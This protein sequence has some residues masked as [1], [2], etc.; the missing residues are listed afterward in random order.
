MLKGKHEDGERLPKTTSTVD[1][2]Q[3]PRQDDAE[4][5]TPRWKPLSMCPMLPESKGSVEMIAV[6]GGC[7]HVGDGSKGN[8]DM[9][10][11]IGAVANLPY[12]VL[13]IWGS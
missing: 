5:T 11:P 13:C 10:S 1:H 3:Q 8:V 12:I 9:K 2:I 4:R 6:R 7:G